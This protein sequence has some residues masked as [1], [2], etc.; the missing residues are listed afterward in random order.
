MDIFEYRQFTTKIAVLKIIKKI[1]YK[2]LLENEINELSKIKNEQRK[3]EFITVRIIRNHL[4]GKKKILYNEFG[5]PYIENSKS[6]ISIS[7]N[8]E[9]AVIAWSDD[10]H[11]G[12]DIEKED[13]DISMIEKKFISNNEEKLLE[14]DD[15]N[16]NTL[17][18]WCIKEALYKLYQ[19]KELDFL[20]DLNCDKV[21]TD[22]WKGSIKKDKKEYLFFIKKFRNNIICFNFKT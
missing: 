3:Q 6:Y 2:S 20:N 16:E 19:K 13:R 15:K 9:Y 11:V 14:I 5:A 10:H 21:N 18:I 17:K 12:V 7:H 1:Y 8:N 4:F 22:I